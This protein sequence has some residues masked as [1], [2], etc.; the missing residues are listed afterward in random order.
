MNNKIVFSLILLTSSL[1][2]ANNP[3]TPST[4]EHDHSSFNCKACRK[5]YMN[6]MEEAATKYLKD[7]NIPYCDRCNEYA[8]LGIYFLGMAKAK[9]TNPVSKF[10]KRGARYTEAAE[11]WFAKAD[12]CYDQNNLKRQIEL[13]EPQTK[14]DIKNVIS[15]S[16]QQPV[17]EPQGTVATSEM[18]NNITQ[19]PSLTEQTENHLKKEY[20]RP[21]FDPRG[22]FGR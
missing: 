16:L 3:S 20:P 2:Y 11:T 5:S 17:A 22:W 8:E 14:Q 6:S 15:T 4:A 12:T 9:E 10:F 1:V 13:Q 19:Q 18:Q 7:G 21:W